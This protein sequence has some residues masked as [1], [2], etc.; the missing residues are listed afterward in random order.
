VA[1]ILLCLILVEVCLVGFLLPSIVNYTSDY[2]PFRYYDPWYWFNAAFL[3]AAILVTM[4]LG[5]LA[6]LLPT[7]AFTRWLPEIFR[8]AGEHPYRA[9]AVIDYCSQP[10][11]ACVSDHRCLYCQRLLC[12]THLG[13]H[14]FEERQAVTR[15]LETFYAVLL[16]PV[17]LLELYVQCLAV[18]PESVAVSGVL[19]VVALGTFAAVVGHAR[20]VYD[21]QGRIMV[22]AQKAP[23]HRLVLAGSI[24]LVGAVL[25]ADVLFWFLRPSPCMPYPLW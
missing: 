6:N 16:G 2:N 11:C 15:S 4:V 17:A 21:G 5:K 3:P 20:F 18:G 24:I 19:L 25:F 10:G 12:A 1:E 13:E 14:R 22:A 8:K 7:G 9:E 23:W